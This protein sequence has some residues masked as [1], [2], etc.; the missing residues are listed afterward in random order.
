[1]HFLFMLHLLVPRDIFNEKMIKV[2][3][4]HAG[5]LKYLDSYT[6]SCEVQQNMRKTFLFLVKSLFIKT[7]RIMVKACLQW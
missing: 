6:R 2:F 1:M 5:V 7:T 4:M 3:F